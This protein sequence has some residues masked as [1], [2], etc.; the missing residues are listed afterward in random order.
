[1]SRFVWSHTVSQSWERR[2]GCGIA[3]ARR[4]PFHLRRQRESL[5]DC[6]SLIDR[7]EPFIGKKIVRSES[8]L[9]Y[10]YER[11]ISRMQR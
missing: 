5:R 2:W 4:V 7:L 8:Y 6:D 9:L 1:M 11:S 3:V 10:R